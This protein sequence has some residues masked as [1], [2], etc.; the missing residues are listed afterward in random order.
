MCN[1][2]LIFEPNES[3]RFYKHVVFYHFKKKKKKK[4]LL[5]AMV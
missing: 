2:T 1:W 4:R 5:N 3:R